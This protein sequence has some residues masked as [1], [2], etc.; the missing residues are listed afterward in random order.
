M[1]I[2]NYILIIKSS[3]SN[4]YFLNVYFKPGTTLAKK[5]QNALLRI[6]RKIRISMCLGL[7]PDP[8]VQGTDPDP[9]IIK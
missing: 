7:D 8:L 2:L 6:R 4:I 3:T 9:S 5:V 1:E